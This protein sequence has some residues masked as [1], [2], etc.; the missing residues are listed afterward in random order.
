M[1]ILAMGYIYIFY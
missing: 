1:G